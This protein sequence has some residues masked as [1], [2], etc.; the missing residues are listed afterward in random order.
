LT[1][2]NIS[3]R[4]TTQRHTQTTETQKKQKKKLDICGNHLF[5]LKESDKKMQMGDSRSKISKTTTP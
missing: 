2:V 5:I 1:E 4:R 3:R